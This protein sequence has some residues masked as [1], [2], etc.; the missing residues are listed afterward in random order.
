MQGF[1]KEI[2]EAL[3]ISIDG[4][5]YEFFSGGL[6][7]LESIDP[8]KMKSVTAS[9]ITA[10]SSAK[11]ILE[12]WMGSRYAPSNDKIRDYI[13][14]LI[15]SG[16]T[17]LLVLRA[18]LSTD[19]N[20]DL[21]EAHK[22]DAA[23]KAKPIILEAV[24]ELAS[25]IDELREK[26]E[27]DDFSLEDK[28]FKLGY[29]ERFAKG[30]FY[31]ASDY[32]KDWYST[33][34]D[35]V[36]LCPHGTTGEIIEIDGLNIALPQVPKDKTKILFHDKKKEDQYWIRPPAPKITKE[37]IDQW[38]DVVKEEFR[39]RREGIW[40]M[41]NGKPVYLTGNHYFGLT[42]CKMLDS[43]GYMDFRYAQLKMY[44][45]MEACLI[46]KRCLG[47]L[48]VKSRRTG[49]T[50][51]LL[52]IML[53]QSTSTR[54]SN[55]GMTSKSDDDAKKAF[56][57]YAYM[58]KNL[59]FY[60]MPTIKGK[61]DSPVSIE[62]NAP[63]LNTR[64]AKKAQGLYSDDYLN[65]LV[66]YQPTKEDSYDGQKMKLYLGDESGK[67]AR[68]LDYIKHFGQI[69]PTMDQ[70]GRI[71]GKAFIGS[72]V[73]PMNKGG[74]AFKSLHSL[75]N[76]LERD[77]VTERT[78]SGLY[79]FF[80]AAQDNM[81]AHTDIYGV[82][83]VTKPPKKTYNN[84]GLLIK[85]GSEDYLIAQEEA[86]KKDKDDRALNE[87]YRAF[88]RNIDY[89][90]RDEAGNSVFN[91]TKIE[92]QLD[93]NNKVSKGYVTGNFEWKTVKDGLVEFIPSKAGRFRVKWLPSKADGTE[94]LANRV[95]KIG[96]LFAPLNDNMV[97]F[98]CD[99]FSLKSTHGKGS[100]G[101]IHG[102]SMMFPDDN[103]IPSNEF[104]V[105][106]IARPSDETIFFEDV[107]KVIRYYGAPILVES[108]R[109]DLLRHMRNRGYRKFAM[110]RLD[111]RKDQ[112]NENEKEYGGQPMSGKDIIDSHMNSIGLWIEKYVGYS[113]NEEYRPEGEIGTIV[114]DETLRDW[115]KFDPENRTIFD[116]TISSGLAI[117]ACTDTKYRQ[118]KKERKKVSIAG[119][120][121]MYKN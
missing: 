12:K 8:D 46:D 96:D 35:A 55:F 3:K 91:I 1:S 62:Y 7:E 74:E 54:N 83:H 13:E 92:D 10:F 93:H 116:A 95:K 43:G 18:A 82:C 60:F 119:I 39:R 45:H 47:Q 87:Q 2:E 100:K 57:K 71:V 121:Q 33:K 44:Y 5:K 77:P 23:L 115:S 69:K 84:E 120:V 50:Y 16:D 78:K 32:H 52:T 65:T 76:V 117:M 86:L 118:K 11:R 30:E 75:S 90:F 103:S 113:T 15:E 70:G 101:A 89:A 38:I 105:E 25:S 85:I 99:P 58:M 48:F 102:L 72:T 59:P 108:N 111:R 26:L 14:Q 42:H 68:G 51:I 20:F 107:I 81:E 109:I 80:L 98:G 21:L 73:G 64:E 106:Y 37:N 53:N 112:L 97:R 66:D 41:N 29:A 4:L 19:I 67:W 34:Y 63:L 17:A 88:P 28:E 94:H 49:F 31:P 110:D 9:K 104:V 27:S 56:L 6:S 61:L 40:F 24:F 79:S 22:H 36:R 114:F